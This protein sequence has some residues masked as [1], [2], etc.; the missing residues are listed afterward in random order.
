MMLRMP[1]ISIRDGGSWILPKFDGSDQ[2]FH[3]LS[4]TVTMCYNLW[5]ELLANRHKSLR[6][7][8]NTV[9]RCCDI[10]SAFAD[11]YVLL[12]F[13]T[14]IYILASKNHHEYT[15]NA[16]MRYYESQQINTNQH[17]PL[18]TSRS[19]ANRVWFVAFLEDFLTVKNILHECPEPTRSI[20]NHIQMRYVSLRVLRMCHKWH[21]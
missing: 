11:C 21:S 2:M 13:V 20:E 4:R 5:H 10:L 7:V 1:K 17:A 14:N 9:P 15:T 12:R 19:N 8:T 16:A 3:A 18:R 6:T